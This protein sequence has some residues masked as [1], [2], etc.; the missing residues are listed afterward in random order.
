M[1]GRCVDGQT[2]RGPEST[3]VG[4]PFLKEFV[5]RERFLSREL[6]IGSAVRGSPFWWNG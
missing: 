6:R 1:L 4:G 2:L 3:L 5:K